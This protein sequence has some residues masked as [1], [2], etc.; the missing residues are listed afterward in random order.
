MS[1][2]PRARAWTRRVAIGLMAS[3]LALQ[4]WFFAWIVLWKWHNPGQTAFMQQ[5]LERMERQ[6]STGP[7]HPAQQ[8]QK[9]WVDYS[10][11][12]A[13]LK[14][15]VVSSEDQRFVSHEGVDWEATRKAYADN[16]HRGRAV[17]GGSTISQQ[18]AKNLFLSAHRT[19]LRKAQE[20][21]IALMIEIIWDKRRILEVYLNVVQWGDG[22]F[23]AEAAARHY[24]GTSALYLD[25]EQAARMAAMLPSPRFFDHHRDAAYLSQRAETIERLLPAAQIP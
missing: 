16:L 20:L 5:E 14:R 15:A 13:N 12:S 7:T 9:V 2:A 25:A 24:F 22:V 10:H 8:L 11:I 23:G 1:V 21:L 18:L 17:R 6:S 19:Y 3:V 4:L